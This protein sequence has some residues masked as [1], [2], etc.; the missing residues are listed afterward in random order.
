VVDELDGKTMDPAD[1]ANK[2]K[3]LIRA[4]TQA[5]AG[6]LVPKCD[7]SDQAILIAYLGHPKSGFLFQRAFTLKDPKG[8]KRG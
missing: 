5:A 7:Y 8:V 6:T 3:R 4:Y 2:A 1:A